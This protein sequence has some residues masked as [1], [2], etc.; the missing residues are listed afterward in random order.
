[1]VDGWCNRPPRARPLQPG[2]SFTRARR[3]KLLFH[4][5]SGVLN[6][7]RLLP[8]I[9]PCLIGKSSFTLSRN[10]WARSS[11]YP[12]PRNLMGLDADDSLFLSGIFPI[13]KSAYAM[14]QFT[15]TTN[16]RTPNS[17]THVR[18]LLATSP[19]LLRPIGNR[20]IAISK[21]AITLHGKILNAE[22][23]LFRIADTCPIRD[24]RP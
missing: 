16:L 24:P 6:T 17:D 14:L 1:L 15:G 13:R 9:S 10:L 21:T 18:S 8:T 12:K 2:P 3:V 23:R 7:H 20:V 19:L 22:S 4:P 11:C 5:L